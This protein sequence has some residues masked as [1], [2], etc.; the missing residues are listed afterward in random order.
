MSWLALA[1]AALGLALDEIRARRA[2]ERFAR[3]PVQTLV[4]GDRCGARVPADG[5][6]MAAHWSAHNDQKQDR[7]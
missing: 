6:S 2:A 3:G 1:R 5:A 4:T 7:R